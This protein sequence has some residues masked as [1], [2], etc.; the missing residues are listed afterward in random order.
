MK[1]ATTFEFAFVLTLA[2]GCGHEQATVA[3]AADGGASVVGDNTTDASARDTG[4]DGAGAETDGKVDALDGDLGSAADHSIDEHG[5]QRDAA[6][7][8]TPCGADGSVCA[9]GEVCIDQIYVDSNG[10]E[11]PDGAI[12]H[13]PPTSE[14]SCVADPC[15]A[16]PTS[17]CYC[18]LCAGGPT[19]CQAAQSTVTCM[20]APVCAS[21]DTPIS[22]EDGER[23]IDSLRAGDLVYSAD[24]D[25]LRL[26]PILRV[27]R[28]AVSR[29]H[30]IELTLANGAVLRMSAGHPTADGRFIGDL[31]AADRLDGVAVVSR[32]EIAYTDLYTYDILPA[33]DTHT[34]VAAGV[35]VGSTLGGVPAPTRAFSRF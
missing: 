29:H 26:V 3:N 22:T 11:A 31:R 32:R 21:Y 33:S 1:R 12:T 15:E 34:Y 4:P 20:I 28:T 5:P 8:T 18:Q 10:E 27:N 24:R 35:L 30:V 6:V 7:S 13:A 19:G 17:A 23:P 25:S 16:S 9:S 14:Y 2:P